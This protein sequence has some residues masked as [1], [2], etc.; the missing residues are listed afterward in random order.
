M[1][2]ASEE[3]IRAANRRFPALVRV[4][5]LPEDTVYRDEGCDVA[6]SCLAC[7]LERCRYDGPGATINTVRA[8]K[9]RELARELVGLG[10]SIDEIAATT[11][12][13]RRTVFRYLSE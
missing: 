8:N 2:T 9:R 11:G 3:E 4:D 1:V 10:Y 13:S 12:A 7:P 6:P 5:A